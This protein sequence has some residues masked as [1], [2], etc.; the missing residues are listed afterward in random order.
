M[1]F[2]VLFKENTS[3]IYYYEKLLREATPVKL[4]TQTNISHLKGIH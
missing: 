4:K 2:N 3:T 1:P